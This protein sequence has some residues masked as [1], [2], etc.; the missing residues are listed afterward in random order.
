VPAKVKASI[1]ALAFAR[2]PGLS[3][4]LPLPAG[5]GLYFSGGFARQALGA[6]SLLLA[7]AV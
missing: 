1:A 5:K 7:E 4:L 2:Q 6:M 3:F